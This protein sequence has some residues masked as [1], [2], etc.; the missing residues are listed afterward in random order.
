MNHEQL[1]NKNTVEVLKIFQNMSDESKLTPAF[2]E[3]I[4][5]DEFFKLIHPDIWLQSLKY[6][7]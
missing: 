7:K 2:I 4:K 3:I 6:L 5:S 1:S